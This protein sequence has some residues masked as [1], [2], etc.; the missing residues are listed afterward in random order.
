MHLPI[1]NEIKALQ[2]TSATVQVDTRLEGL[3]M[4]QIPTQALT[5]AATTTVTYPSGTSTKAIS[6]VANRLRQGGFT[7]SVGAST[8]VITWPSFSGE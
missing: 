3:C 7:V 6:D 2:A 8:M 1:Y 5:G 4:A